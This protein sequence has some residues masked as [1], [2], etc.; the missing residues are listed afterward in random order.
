VPSFSFSGSF[1]YNP[2]IIL[3]PSEL[4]S[5]Y[6][7]GVNLNYKGKSVPSESLNFFIKTGQSYLERVLGIK[8]IRQLINESQDLYYD[9]WLN[10]SYI[11]TSFPVACPKGLSGFI[12]EI[13]VA[14]YPKEWMSA[15]RTNDPNA[16]YPRSIRLIPNKNGISIYSNY[17]YTNSLNMFNFSIHNGRQMPNYW[18]LS[19]VTGWEP[20]KIPAE[21][22]KII[23]KLAAIETLTS[24]GEIQFSL[25]GVSSQSISIDGLSQSLSTA[26]GNTHPFSARLKS[27]SDQVTNEIKVI[28]QLYRQPFMMVL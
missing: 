22:I 13:K 14:E 23:G 10:W 11:S 6:L 27:L 7:Q 12:G 26:A 25:I 28:T 2:S 8:L 19:Y 9:D 20:D 3:S 4:T 15:F 5:Y 1:Q 18:E 24:V 21:L 17:L 16:I